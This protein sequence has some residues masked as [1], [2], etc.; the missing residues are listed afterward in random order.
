MNKFAFWP[1]SLR[2][3]KRVHRELGFR[4]QIAG[5]LTIHYN[6]ADTDMR[7]RPIGWLVILLLGIAPAK[8]RGLRRSP[9]TG[10]T[11]D[12]EKCAIQGAVTQLPTRGP[13]KGAEVVLTAGNRYR[14]LYRTETDATGQFTLSDVEPGKYRIGI[15]KTAYESSDRRCDSELVQNGDEL[16][17][18]SGQKLT[19]LQFQLLTPAVIAGTVFDPS[20]DPVTGARVQAVRFH[21]FRGDLKLS[22]SGRTATTDDRGQFR[23]Y[24][25]SP[26][27][28]FLRVEDA[29]DFRQRLEGQKDRSE[30]GVKGFLPIYYPDTT[31]L[32]QA[33]LFKLHPGEELRGVDFTLHPARVLQIRGRAVNGLTEDRIND[34]NVAIEALPPAIRENRGGGITLDQVDQQFIISD[35]VPGRYIVS[36]LGWVPP[37]RKRWGGWQEIELTDSSLDDFQIKA[38]PGQ[39]IVGRIQGIG[40]KKLDSPDLQVIL[41][42]RSDVAYGNAFANAKADGSFLLMDVEQDTYDISVAGLPEGYYLKSARFGNIEAID[43]LRIVGEPPTSPLILEA[44]PASGRVDGTVQTENGKSA[45]EATVVLIPDG[46]RRSVERYYQDTE[47]DHFGRFALQGVAPGAYKLFAFDDANEVGYRDPGS[48]Q[49]YENQGQP[50]QLEE[51]DHRSMELKLIPTGKKKP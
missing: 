15:G 46:N 39:D 2:T 33:T 23:L 9:Q 31:D 30:K 37:E 25:L 42:P 14:P 27:Q 41:D 1:P 29:F 21:S 35:L 26:G 34:V 6:R 45:C 36:V 48:L 3:R 16:T 51:G 49:P 50:V 38:F 20:G 10:S 19:G 8:L 18:V 43:G 13:L 5:I 4:Q 7:V 11:S 47:V 44:S 22:S 12:A 32:S 40:G 17:L 28:Y 24:H